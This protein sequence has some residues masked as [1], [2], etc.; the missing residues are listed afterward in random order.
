[1]DV[2]NEQILN[3]NPTDPDNLSDSLFSGDEENAGTEEIKNEI[4]GNWIS[5][6][7]INEARINAKAKRRLRKNSSRDSGRGD[8]VSDNGSEALRSGITVPT[9]PKGRLLDRRSRSGKGRGLPKKG[10]AGGKGVWGT[11]GQ[12]YDVEEVDVKDPNYDDDQLVGQFIARAVGDGILCNTYIDSYKGTVD[13][14]QARAALDKATVLLSMS[15]GGRRKDSVWGSGGGQQSVNH[16]VKEIDMLLKEY[17]LSG[18]I[19]EA[20][21]CLK[22]LEVPHFHH[23]LVYEAIVMV[24][25]STG[26]STFRMILDLLKSLWK[27]YTITVDQMKR[28]YE[29]IYNEIPDINLDVPHSYSVLERFVEECFQAG[30]ISK[31]LRDLCPSRGRK[32]FVSEGDGGRL[33][34]ESY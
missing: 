6:S 15:K 27:S 2:E 14:V 1:M 19:S 21:H 18:D 34:P 24:L 11:P 13:C 5:A 26:E 7:S 17:L 8:S 28:G 10:G 9:S 30:I 12:V 22:E 32:R 29:R 4:N 23:E 33:K 20:E 25:E 16:L 3:V 31:Q